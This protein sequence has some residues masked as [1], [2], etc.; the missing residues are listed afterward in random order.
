MKKNEYIDPDNLNFHYK[1]DERLKTLD[2]SVKDKGKKG[3]FK[4]NR[5]LKII[6]FD[7]LIIILAAIILPPLLKSREYKNN[8]YGC[9]IRLECFMLDDSILASLIIEKKKD[10]PDMPEKINA[11][12]NLKGTDYEESVSES[13]VFDSGSSK[14]YIRTGLDI[15]EDAEAVTAYIKF[16]EKEFSLMTGIKGK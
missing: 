16:G 10:D 8:V 14:T 6:L 5:Q 12:Y 3:F 2:P 15:Y 11:V 7:I 1:R 13:I 4:K 9:N